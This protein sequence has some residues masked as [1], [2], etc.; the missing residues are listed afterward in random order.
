M[1]RSSSKIS[2][3]RSLR[4]LWCARNLTV[5]DRPERETF[6]RPCFKRARPMTQLPALSRMGLYAFLPS[7]FPIRDL[8]ALRAQGGVRWLVISLKACGAYKLNQ[9]MAQPHRHV[10]MP[11]LIN[12]VDEEG[13]RSWLDFLPKDYM[14]ARSYEDTSAS[15]P[16]KNKL[17][18]LKIWR[19]F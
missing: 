3:R 7:F 2:H 13:W 1:F 16:E 8:N 10:S 14:T 6:G 17:G 4:W 5:K 11:L 12:Y 9:S 15:K 18:I 19:S